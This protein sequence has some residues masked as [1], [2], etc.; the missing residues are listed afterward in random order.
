MR[1]IALVTAFL[2]GLGPALAMAEGCTHA[3]QQ[4]AEISC[5]EGQVWDAK[6]ARCVVL[7]S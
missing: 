6:E 5:A 1:I 2:G 7:D 4:S 3:R